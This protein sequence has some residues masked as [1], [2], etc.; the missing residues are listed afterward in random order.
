MI[1]PD[2]QSSEKL[3]KAS[4]IGSGLAH[5]LPLQLQL[6]D[7]QPGPGIKHMIQHVLIASAGK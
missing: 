7:F 4:G 6:S 5:T 3:T 2:L 1:M